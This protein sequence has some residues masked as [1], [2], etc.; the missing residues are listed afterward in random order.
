MKLNSKQ[1]IEKYYGAFNAGDMDTFL[2]LLAEDVVHDINQTHFEQGKEA[3]A[4][5][6]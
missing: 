5:F 6:M 4:R 3:F 1:I 2:Q